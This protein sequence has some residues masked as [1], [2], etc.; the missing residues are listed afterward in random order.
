M[1][2][3]N[4]VSGRGNQR[5]F[6]EAV[7]AKNRGVWDKELN[8]LLEYR[9]LHESWRKYLHSQSPCSPPSSS[10]STT[11]AAFMSFPTILQPQT[12]PT[13]PSIFQD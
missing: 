10:C 6:L 1:F 8:V 13:W 3:R 2:Q 5:R 11:V 9:E 12:V 7:A 4:L